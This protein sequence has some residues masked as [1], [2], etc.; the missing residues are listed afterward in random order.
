GDGVW[1][2]LPDWHPFQSVVFR[3][4]QTRKSLLLDI[5]HFSHGDSS[6]NP[7]KRISARIIMWDVAIP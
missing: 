5:P 7:G 2:S 6:R 4:I 1:I 3:S